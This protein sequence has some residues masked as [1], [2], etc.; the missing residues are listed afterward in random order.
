MALYANRYNSINYRKMSPSNPPGPH[1]TTKRPD[2]T[3]AMVNG[4]QPTSTNEAIPVVSKHCSVTSQR[5]PAISASAD[6]EKPGVARCNVVEGDNSPSSMKEFHEFV[7]APLH[8]SL[9]LANGVMIDTNATTHPL[10][11]PRP[12]RPDIPLGHIHRLPR[13]GLQYPLLHPRRANHKPELLVSDSAGTLF[14]PG[15]AI[16]SIRGQYIQGE[17]RVR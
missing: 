7:N 16:P 1:V 13:S 17:A 14:Y 6:I 5:V 3:D 2:S 15:S 8:P 9:N 10:L 12:R 4:D 11:G